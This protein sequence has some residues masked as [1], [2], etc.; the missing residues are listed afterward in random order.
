L[1]E[2]QGEFWAGFDKDIDRIGAELNR[3]FEEL[4]R[5]HEQTMQSIQGSIGDIVGSL[6]DMFGTLSERMAEEGKK[7]ANALFYTAQASMLVQAEMAAALAAI[8][9]W[10]DLGPI[11]GALAFGAVAASTATGVMAIRNAEPPVAHTGRI[12]GDEARMSA[13]VQAG[14]V[15]QVRSAQSVRREGGEAAQRG[16][17]RPVVVPV[18]VY[19]HTIV[20]R[21]SR[22]AE[23]LETTTRRT[24]RAGI[25]WQSGGR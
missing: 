9:V 19:D 2:Q 10:S 5:R 13:T 8:R 25:S 18:A 14:E 6:G 22:R 15:V 3:V 20:E 23:R 4:Q 17:T 7:G 12:L 24:L 16:S 21:G 1:A 11:A